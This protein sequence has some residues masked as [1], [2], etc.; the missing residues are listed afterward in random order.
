MKIKHC[1]LLFVMV[2]LCTNVVFAER[3]DM[4]KAGAKADGKKLNTLLINNT[5]DRLSSNG[6]GI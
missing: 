5:I 4:L 1:F 6:G 2:F 3:V